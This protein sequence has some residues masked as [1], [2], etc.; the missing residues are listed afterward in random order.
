[1][2]FKIEKLEVWQLAV[3]YVDLIYETRIWGK[4]TIASHT[5]GWHIP[6]EHFY[7]TNLR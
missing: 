6:S 1:M 3:D 2:P 7:P 4:S 5:R